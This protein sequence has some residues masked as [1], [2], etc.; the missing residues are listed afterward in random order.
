MSTNTKH[1]ADVLADW[2]ESEGVTRTADE[3]AAM[4]RAIPA[5]EAERDALRTELVKLKANNL[6]RRIAAPG[7]AALIRTWHKGF[8][9][10]AEVIDWCDVSELQDGLHKLYTAPQAAQPLTDEQARD[11]AA[12]Y[13]MP[14]AAIVDIY[15]RALAAAHQAAQP[16]PLTYDQIVDALTDDAGLNLAYRSYEDDMKFAR[17]IERAHGIGKEGGAA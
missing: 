6:A 1:Q 17:A 2:I 10:H 11:I 14:T 4:L 7:P 5:L 16:Q 13:D 9:Q 8:D 12:H 3:A 15:K